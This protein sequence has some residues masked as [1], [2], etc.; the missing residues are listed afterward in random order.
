[1]PSAKQQDPSAHA[2]LH[3][4]PDIPPDD[5]A[6]SSIIKNSQSDCSS[7]GGADKEMGFVAKGFSCIASFKFWHISYKLHLDKSTLLHSSPS[8][9]KQQVAN[10]QNFAHS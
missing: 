9:T 7:I 8:E 1:M 5:G 10:A 6:G 4:P 3:L 2:F